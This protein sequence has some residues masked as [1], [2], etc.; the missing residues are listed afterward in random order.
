MF[1]TGSGASL[2]GAWLARRRRSAGQV[3]SVEESL[4]AGRFWRYAL[5]RLT[6]FLMSRAWGI[7]LHVVELTWLSHVFSAKVFVASL[8]LQN[9]TL[10]LD[11]WFFGALEGLRRRVRELGAGSE[12]AA[13]TARWL[14]GALWV[15]IAIVLV[16]LGR[17]VYGWTDD[18]RTPTM[19]HVY[20]FVCGLRLAADI[21]LR[22]Y[23]SGV[24][25]HHRVY[26]PLWTP[27]VPPALTVGVTALLWSRLG[28]WA[29]PIA[30]TSSLLASRT[31]LFVYTRRAYRLRRVPPPRWR[32]AP[33][34]P[35]VD[36]GLFLNAALA[37]LANITTRLGGVVLLAA[38]IPSL[39]RPSSEFF[40]DEVPAVEPF[41]FALH[42]AAPMLFIAGQWGLV[43]YHDWKR[44]EGELSDSLARH[45]HWR[46][47]V[48]ACVVGF[49]AWLGASA[50]VV[51]WVSWEETWPTLLALFPA[52][53]GLS[54]WTALQL[55]GFARG[56]FG[57]Q[58]ASALGMLAALWLTLSSS[59]NGPI[60]WYL[61]LAAGPWI[62]IALHALFELRSARGKTGEL[63]L[64]ATWVRA[65]ESARGEVRAWEARVAQRPSYV[66]ARIASSLGER[67]AA[68]R[69]GNQ[70]LW[71]ERAPFADRASW[72][73]LGAG[74]FVTLRDAGLATGQ[75]HRA[76]L[77][78]D[79][80]LGRPEH[81]TLSSLTRAHEHLFPGGF[82]LRV[83]RRPPA[84]F[85]ALP[86]TSRQAIW[87]DGLR[88]QRRIRGRSAWFVTT[89][90]PRG[91]AE[92]LFV[93]PRPIT[94]EQ[95]QA[96]HTEIAPFTWR[97]LPP[98][99]AGP[100]SASPDQ[101]TLQAAIFR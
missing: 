40:E 89:F 39:A 31:I 1:E 56:E 75:A 52:M 5:R 100:G 33:R 30:L 84:S 62:A 41:A 17:A 72:L 82:V 57:R 83:G 96:W 91:A 47:L 66:T 48:T 3:V 65:L 59:I 44:L 67:G 2:L 95:A 15:G 21:V 71:F 19:F 73:R 97:I 77:E 61:A 36:V 70:I 88:H 9:A 24:F 90:A 46:L 87:R 22:T 42:L 18:Q 34:R 74:A 92:V 6:V 64:V 99:A 25:A 81:T 55:R 7:A 69:A 53:M 85:E 79:A 37:G 68:V 14:T 49:F 54:V 13:L 50:L 60:A 86:P 38:V 63:S 12:A 58:V 11:A 43:F 10:V 98:A 28:G 80:R 8:A 26:R 16:P 29:F 51:A 93:A 76:K 35:K 78:A 101:G 32:L 4:L 94:S 27:L 23:Y 20:A 45:L